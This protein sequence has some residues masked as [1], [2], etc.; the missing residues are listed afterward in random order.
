MRIAFLK[1]T[2]KEG[3]ATINDYVKEISG[4]KFWFNP[5]L[6]GD[7]TTGVYSFRLDKDCSD[8]QGVHPGWPFWEFDYDMTQNS[9][10]LL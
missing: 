4:G 9:D 7:N 3:T 10:F 5:I 1:S 8:A 2:Y 6:L